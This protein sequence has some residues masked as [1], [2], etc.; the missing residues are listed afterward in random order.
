MNNSPSILH[1]FP[2]FK[3]GGAQ[4]RF[5][6]LAKG[7]GDRFSH[8]VIAMDGQYAAAQFLPPDSGIT[9][10]GLPAVGGSLME[11]LSRYRRDIAAHAP[12][13]LVTYNW[14]SIEWALANLTMGTPH[15]HIEDG[16]GPEEAQRQFLRRV[17]TRRLALRRSQVIV[18]SLTLRNLALQVWRLDSARVHYIPNGIA[19]CDEFSTD[20][21]E[22]DLD[23]P[24]DRPRIAWA[25]AIRREK[26]LIRLLRAFAP[27]K[28]QAVLLVIGDGSELDNALR[29]SESLSLGPAI[30]FLGRRQDVRDIFMQ[31][32][33]MALSSDTEQM[34]LAVLEAMDAGLPVASTDVGDVRH[35]V[36]RENQPYIVNGSD[37]ELGAALRAL[38][39][40]AAARKG[41]GAANR[42]RLRQD[43]QAKDMIAAYEA[44]FRRSAGAGS[45]GLKTSA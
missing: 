12:D 18:P 37:H 3:I 40:D 21:A 19:P 23:L 35:M 17:W 41:I 20:I 22:L 24:P 34:P 45:R 11:R 29:E 28:D 38:V 30:R 4:V 25:G 44:L 43:Y 10:G 8:T 33:L 13:L 27:L 32:D 36:S 2:T 5:A 6:E 39:T 42:R 9:L 31:C 1:V 7:F 14:G 16:F 26:N 15:I